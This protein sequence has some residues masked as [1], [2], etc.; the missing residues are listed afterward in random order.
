MELGG[1][2]VALGQQRDYWP[3][4]SDTQGSA[5]GGLD[6]YGFTTTTIERDRQ[7]SA[8]MTSQLSWRSES[9]DT[10]DATLLLQGRHILYLASDQRSSYLGTP[11]DLASDDFSSVDDSGLARAAI[12]WKTATGSES[13]LDSKLTLSSNGRRI[14]AAFEG[15]NA[16]GSPLLDRSVHSSMHDD[17]VI[18]TGKYSLNLGDNHALGLG[19]DGQ[20]GTRSEHRVQQ[21]TSEVGYPTLDLDEDYQATIERMAVFVQDEWTVSKSISAYLGIRWEG[22][23]TRT[24]G[25]DIAA[26]KTRSS[27]FSPTFQAIWRIP[28]SKSDQV[29]FAVGRTYKAPTARDLLPRRWVVNQNGPTTPDFRGNPSLRIRRTS[30]SGSAQPETDRALTRCQGRATG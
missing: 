22:L 28:D 15:R 8:S 20:A 4:T 6:R 7:E 25:N 27:V 23:R 5:D 9:G 14:G 1:V 10:V 16:S 13:R 30:T 11:P 29:R 26:V 2:G 21:E 17:T 18:G 3:S 24:T 12:Q 19:W